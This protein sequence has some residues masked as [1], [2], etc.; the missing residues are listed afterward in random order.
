[1]HLLRGLSN[2]LKS[3]NYALITHKCKSKHLGNIMVKWYITRHGSPWC[4]WGSQGKENLLTDDSRVFSCFILGFFTSFQVHTIQKRN[5][6]GKN[7]AFLYISKISPN[8]HSKIAHKINIKNYIYPVFLLVFRGSLFAKK[9]CLV[10]GLIY[11][12]WMTEWAQ[13]MGLISFVL[14]QLNCITN[15]FFPL[16]QVTYRST[17]QFKAVQWTF[18]ATSPLPSSL[19]GSG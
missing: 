1:M 14:R 18:L 3:L 6:K 2:Y 13:S 16:F 9:I 11:T 8:N 5:A 17:L 4:V 15:P 7:K 12:I 19:I 10:I